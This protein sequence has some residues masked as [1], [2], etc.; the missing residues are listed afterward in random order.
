MRK[1]E[2]ERQSGGGERETIVKVEL[3][4]VHTLYEV[5]EGR[6]LEG[7]DLRVAQFAVRLKVAGVD[8][9]QQLLRHLDHLLLAGCKWKGERKEKRRRKVVD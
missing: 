6:R 8:R 4:E 5:A 7:G 3:M 2:R 9:L 1:S